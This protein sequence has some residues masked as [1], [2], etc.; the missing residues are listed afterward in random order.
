MIGEGAYPCK[1]TQPQPHKFSSVSSLNIFRCYHHDNAGLACAH[2]ERRV[3]LCNPGGYW[4][5]NLARTPTPHTVPLL[6]TQSKG[7][8]EILEWQAARNTRSLT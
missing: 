1:C 3:C 8:G 6:Q 7:T 5:G 4:G 2:G